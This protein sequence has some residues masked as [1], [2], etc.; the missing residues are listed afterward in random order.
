M[1]KDDVQT[2]KKREL[3]YG[4]L[5]DEEQEPIKVFEHYIHC[6]LPKLVGSP[7]QIV[8]AEDIQI[9]RIWE[10]EKILNK[11]D[12]VDDQLIVQMESLLQNADARFWIDSRDSK[13]MNLLAYPYQFDRRRICDWCGRAY[14]PNLSKYTER[15]AKTCGKACRWKRRKAKHQEYLESIEVENIE[16]TADEDWTVEEPIGEGE[17]PPS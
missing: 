11:S 17:S 5:D 14:Y 12:I 1:S 9:Q 10:F 7:K 8:W 4:E 6:D 16:I 13:I 2:R 15:I 3:E